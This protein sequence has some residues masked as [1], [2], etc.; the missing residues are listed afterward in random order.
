MSTH[1]QRRYDRPFPEIDYEW[2]GQKLVGTSKLYP[3]FREFAYVSKNSATN[4]EAVNIARSHINRK[5]LEY[6]EKN[7]L[8]ATK[9]TYLC[10]EC[11][12]DKFTA[13]Q[14]ARDGAGFLRE[15][16]RACY[17]RKCNTWGKKK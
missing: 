11:R 8:V 14:M 13:I 10:K 3:K 12:D 9:V 4:S 5:F 17:S 16:C 7:N 2:V 1:Y 15:F 6:M